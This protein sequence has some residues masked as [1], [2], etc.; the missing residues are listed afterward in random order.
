MLNWQRKG[1]TETIFPIFLIQFTAVLN[2]LDERKKKRT[3]TRQES[4][5]YHRCFVEQEKKFSCWQFRENT[6]TPQKKKKKRQGKKKS[7]GEI[8]QKK[9]QK[10]YA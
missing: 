9:V 7:W 8:A 4:R 5:T 6:H 10:L 2:E 3:S 1:S